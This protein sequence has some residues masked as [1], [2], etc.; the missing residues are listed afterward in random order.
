MI[1]GRIANMMQELDQNGSERK[2]LEVQLQEFEQ[3]KGELEMERSKKKLL[4][5]EEES[6]IKELDEEIEK[7]KALISSK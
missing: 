3:E 6:R 2:N 5:P 7:L 4:D 1:D